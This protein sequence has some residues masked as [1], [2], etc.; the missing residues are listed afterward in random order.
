[1]PLPLST[2]YMLGMISPKTSSSAAETDGLGCLPRKEWRVPETSTAKGC[3]LDLRSKQR[4]QLLP[5]LEQHLVCS[6]IFSGDLL[7]VASSCWNICSFSCSQYPW[8]SGVYKSNVSLTAWNVSLILKQNVSLDVALFIHT[9]FFPHILMI[10]KLRLLIFLP[11]LNLPP[12][13]FF[14]RYFSM[15]KLT[16]IA[17]Y[18]LSWG[19]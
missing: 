1:M 10:L 6:Q 8:H 5:H 18:G 13:M 11:K 15:Q 3:Q 7:L 16:F 17:L 12:N 2:C 19:Q 14:Y 9:S 4:N